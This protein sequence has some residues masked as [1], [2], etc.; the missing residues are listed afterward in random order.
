M[1]AS[2]LALA[3]CLAQGIALRLVVEP[4]LAPGLRPVV[5]IEAG[6]RRDDALRVGRTDMVERVDLAGAAQDFLLDV[7]ERA[8][9]RAARLI[10]RKHHGGSHRTCQQQTREHDRSPC[11]AGIW[12]NRSQ[13]RL[14]PGDISWCC[15]YRAALSLKSPRMRAPG[16]ERH[17]NT[18]Q[19]SLHCHRVSLSLSQLVIIA[20]S[21]RGRADIVPLCRRA[22]DRVSTTQRERCFHSA[23]RLKGRAVS[24]YVL[25]K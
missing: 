11:L 16:W 15:T 13:E 10:G 8:H 12:A 4:D 2:S 14:A 3:P 18:C 5:A 21:A 6:Q 22:S 19:H 7:V 1:S 24:P 17:T 20:D 9:L 23:L 25:L